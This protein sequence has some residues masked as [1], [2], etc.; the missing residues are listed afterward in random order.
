MAQKMESIAEFA[1]FFTDL[2]GS[3]VAGQPVVQSLEL[4][5]NQF[6][7]AAATLVIETRGR[8][9]ETSRYHFSHSCKEGPSSVDDNGQSLS[10]MI[11]SHAHISAHHLGGD[12]SSHYTLWLFRDRE[13][14]AFD[15]EETALA[16]LVA[17]QLARGIE[18]AW[19]VGSSEVER[20]LYSDALERMNVGVMMVDDHGRVV[21]VSPIAERFLGDRE[22]LCI[23]SGK[24]R[25]LSV[26]EDRLLQEAIRAALRGNDESDRSHGLSLTKRCGTKDL[27]ILVRRINGG[28]QGNS[29]QAVAVYV[30]DATVVQ[31][32]EGDLVRQILD[33]TPAE[34][35]VARRLTE[36]L[37]LD[38]AASSLAISR[39]TARAHLRSIFSKSGI[40]RQTELVRLIMN[41]AAMLGDRPHTPA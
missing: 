4:I 28:L 33:L 20:S 18:L 16:E 36:G 29:G 38:D 35:A 1:R 12:Q 8:T 24:L 14:P 5:R 10:D 3:L 15:T 41:S 34:A 30:R 17:A 40:T 7:A 31:E 37:S 32:I 23:Q 21:R 22:G 27:G 13:A 11:L 26:S 9:G 19:K 6:S 2:V 25:A 39:N